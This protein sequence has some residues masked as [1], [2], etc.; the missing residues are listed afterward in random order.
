M[1][2]SLGS[3][4]KPFACAP[5]TVKAKKKHFGYYKGSGTISND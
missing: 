4:K 1:I 2:T 5:T 3:G